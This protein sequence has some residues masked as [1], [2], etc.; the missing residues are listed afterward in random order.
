M[1]SNLIR[2]ISLSLAT[3]LLGSGCTA[4]VR[5]NASPHA[6]ANTVP[7]DR[8]LAYS[9]QQEGYAAMTVTRDEGF[10][11]GGCYLGLVIEGKIAA[12]FDPNETAT[13]FVPP[14]E[15]N[16]AVVPDPEGRGLCSV[17][18]WDPVAEKYTIQIGVPNHYRISLGAYRRPRLLPSVY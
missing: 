12:R 11:G 8:I 7:A 14:G 4:F 3:L 6:T 13:F 15:R 17:G 1:E 18:G 9:E 16:M 2:A 10:M 5:T